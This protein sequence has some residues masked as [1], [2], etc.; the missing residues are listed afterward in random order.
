MSKHAQHTPTLIPQSPPVR[1]HLKSLLTPHTLLQHHLTP[2]TLLQHHLTP[3]T[4]LQVLCAGGAAAWWRS[5]RPRRRHVQLRV[6]VAGDGHRQ[7][8]LRIYELERAAASSRYPATGQAFM[9]GTPP[10]A[11]AVVVPGSSQST[12]FA[13]YS[14]STGPLPMCM[15]AGGTAA[16]ST[17]G[18]TNPACDDLPCSAGS[19]SS[20]AVW[21][22]DFDPAYQLLGRPP[23]VAYDVVKDALLVA[24]VAWCTS[25]EPGCRPSAA[26]VLHHPYSVRHLGQFPGHYRRGGAGRLDSCCSDVSSMV[27]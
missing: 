18:S 25:S 1:H 12:P 5:G 4:L 3:H 15:P 16:G 8:A 6:P 23:A 20:M 26:Q 24:L 17:A 2:H 9:P 13:A 10:A 21:P 19:S 27:E 11:P 7:G 14:H 22:A